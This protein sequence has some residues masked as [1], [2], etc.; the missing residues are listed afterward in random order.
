M[1][2]GKPS[3]RLN[4]LFLKILFIAVLLVFQSLEALAKDGSWSFAFL[5]D[6]RSSRHETRHG[7][8]IPALSLIAE[9]LA[10]DIR[11]EDTRCELVLFAGDLIRGQYSEDTAQSNPEAYQEWKNVMKPVYEAFRQKSES[12]APVYVVRGN[13]EVYHKKIGTTAKSVLVDWMSAFGDS[14]PQ[15]GPPPPPVEAG[16]VNP[17]KGLNYFVK[18]RDVLFVGVDQY[19]LQQYDPSINLAWLDHT[20]ESEKTGP[21][22][23]VFGHAPAWPA[24]KTRNDKSLFN[25]P[26]L[27]DKF[28]ESLER[29]GCRVYLTGHQHYTAVNVIKREGKPDMWQIISGSAGAPLTTGKPKILDRAKTVYLNNANYGYYL[30][31]VDGDQITMTF[32]YYSEAERKW[33]S[34]KDSVVRYNVR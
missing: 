14:M 11:N 1:T 16:Q 12:P 34:D 25:Y 32:K 33:I 26:E 9:E 23:F 21:H 10:R 29:G 19:V 4:I 17:Q 15:N 8:N 18:Y 20:L 27:R 7:V 2:S 22:V 30:C 6:S 24:I 5:A 31:E 3:S 13:H 28:W